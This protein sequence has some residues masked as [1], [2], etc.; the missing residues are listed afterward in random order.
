MIELVDIAEAVKD[1][2]ETARTANT[3]GVNYVLERTWLPVF[4]VKDLKTLHVT[5]SPV[6]DRE[7]I[8]TR[9]KFQEDLRVD[10]CV[11]KKLPSPLKNAD[12]DPLVVIARSIAKHFRKAKLGT[13]P[14]F[15]CDGI[16]HEPIVA[17]EH[18]EQW[19]QFTSLIQLSFLMHGA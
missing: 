11:M 7:E 6:S 16:L 4:E 1:S 18:L 12:I 19:G 2:L 5:V 14:Q 15:T 17:R 3:F 13:S 10:V 9:A 8:V